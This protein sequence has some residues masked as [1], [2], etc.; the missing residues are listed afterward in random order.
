MYQLPYFFVLLLL[1][2]KPV[3]TDQIPALDHSA[4]R[5]TFLPA[6]GILKRQTKGQGVGTVPVYLDVVI[7]LNFLVDFLLLLGTN[8]LC[9]YP[10]S[11]GKAA[12]AAGLGG[13]YG[14]MCLLPGFSFLGNTLW[15][16]VSLAVMSML[17]FGLQKSA[18]R[19]AVVFIL[20][21]MALGGIA[22]GLGSGNS[23]SLIAAAGGILLLCAVGFRGGVGAATYIP[24]ELCYADRKVC[25]TALRDTG[26]TLRDPVTGRPVLVV[27]A[28]TAKILTG[29]SKEQ[30]EKP[31][32]SITALPGLRLI[33]YRAIGNDS[34]MLLAIQI[35]QV[36]I[37][38]WQGSSLVAFAPEG[39][40]MGGEFQALTGGVV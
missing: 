38:S 27:G 31:V 4:K 36:K 35:P 26:N 24:V 22:L 21:S 7:A 6:A 20:L 40:S 28:E 16:T 18:V 14:G 37:G 19:R 25:I 39:L 5:R 15:R 1:K 11:A 23:I 10:A 33:P 30:L 17:A 13:L 8:R 12:L 3:Q 32:E 29:L 34:G 2:Q 9:G